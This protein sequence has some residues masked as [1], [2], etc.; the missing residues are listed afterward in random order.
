MNKWL[1]FPDD[2]KIIAYTQIAENTGM[3]ALK[4]IKHFSNDCNAIGK[5][6][7]RHYEH[8]VEKNAITHVTTNLSASEIEKAYGN[9]VRSRL[10]QMFNLIA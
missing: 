3:A 2:H 1:E 6:L 8:F 4:Q 10:R 5:I 9:R 7:I